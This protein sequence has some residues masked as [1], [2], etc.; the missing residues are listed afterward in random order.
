MF[1]TFCI[2]NSNFSLPYRAYE[3]FNSVKKVISIIA[4]E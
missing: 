1:F 4:K 3:P 2:V